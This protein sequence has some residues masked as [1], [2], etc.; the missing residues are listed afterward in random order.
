MN[1]LVKNHIVSIKFVEKIKLA[2]IGE[3]VGGKF[4]RLVSWLLPLG[5]TVYGKFNEIEIV[6]VPGI[7]QFAEPMLY[8]L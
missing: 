2:C 1:P 8:G 5:I 3:G 4:Y 6:A 7:F